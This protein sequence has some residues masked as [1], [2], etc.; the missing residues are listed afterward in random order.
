MCHFSEDIFVVLCFCFICLR[1]V[2]CVS[3]VA[4]FPELFVLGCIFD[5]L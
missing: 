1:L 4:N 5:A 2:S 3:G